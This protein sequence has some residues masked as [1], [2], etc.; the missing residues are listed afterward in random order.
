MLTKITLKNRRIAPEVLQQPAACQLLLYAFQFA[1]QDGQLV[2]NL[3]TVCQL[4][5]VSYSQG[6]KA[7]AFLVERGIFH[8]MSGRKKENAT[9]CEAE[10]YEAKA[11]ENAE[12][13]SENPET[14]PEVIAPTFEPE[15]AEEENEKERESSLPPAPLTLKEKEKEREEFL[16]NCRNRAK[17]ERLHS[18]PLMPPAAS[19]E[20]EEGAT[21][22]VGG[23]E[24]EVEAA[25]EVAAAISKVEERQVAAKVREV[26]EHQVT[27][28]V[29]EVEERQ[30][31]RVEAVE[32]EEVAEV[33]EVNVAEAITAAETVVV[34]ESLE[35]PT[36]TAAL[37]REL[38][39]LSRNQVFLNAFASQEKLTLQQVYEALQ[40]FRQECIL[41]N[42]LH[43]KGK[44]DLQ[45]HFICWYRIT[46]KIKSHDQRNKY[47]TAEERRRADRMHRQA[48][49]AALYAK[50]RK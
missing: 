1:D 7:V 45:A 49:Y 5:N 13:G 4:L 44:K 15:T 19:D 23:A 27:A 39:A 42:K 2:L 11:G 25:R 28:K 35:L 34:D 38:E 33:E 37:D 36:D 48:G 6:Q 21:T 8:K 31:Q 32:V 50:Y 20:A 24:T 16:T 18:E 46:V 41:Q 40:R 17:G 30:V 12:V 3:A 29:R 26:E 14:N 47:A 43:H 22:E 10:S 9:D